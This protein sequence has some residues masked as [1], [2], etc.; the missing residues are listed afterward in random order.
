M[1]IDMTDAKAGKA[2]KR[3]FNLKNGRY[4]IGRKAARTLCGAAINITNQN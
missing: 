3:A 2:Q 1:G 4:K